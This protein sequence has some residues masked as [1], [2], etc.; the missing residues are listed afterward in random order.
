MRIYKWKRYRKR[1]YLTKLELKAF[2]LGVGCL[3]P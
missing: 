1:R 3:N 2:T